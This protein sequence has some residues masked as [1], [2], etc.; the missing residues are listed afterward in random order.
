ML[1]LLKSVVYRRF[2]RWGVTRSNGGYFLHWRNKKFTVFQTRKILKKFKNDMKILKEILRF[3]Q[4]VFKIL[5]SSGENI[6][7]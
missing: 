7:K 1:F 2:R 3:F 4:N 6:G 5:S